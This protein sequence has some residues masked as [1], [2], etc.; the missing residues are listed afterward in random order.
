M[1]NSRTFQFYGQ[2]YGSTPVSIIATIGGT[3]VYSG[4]I[5]TVNQPWVPP[6][7]IPTDQTILFLIENSTLLNTDY[8]GSVPMTVT[9]SGGEGVLFGAINCNWQLGA[10]P[11]W[12]EAEAT[13]LLELGGPGL[14]YRIT[15]IDIRSAKASPAFTTDETNFLVNADLSI[16][17]T[18]N[19]FNAMVYEHGVDTAIQLSDNFYSCYNGTP[20]N[21]EG[22]PDTRSS[23]QIDGVTQVPPLPASL[24]TWNWYVPAGSTISYNFNISSIPFGSIFALR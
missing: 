17:S 2:A 19:E 24:G 15:N 16:V 3:E 12:T 6:G 7:A 14:P 1:A 22:T 13:Q 21:S 8:S 10:N 5:P 23:V 18:Q 4:E 9:V 20:T 11:I